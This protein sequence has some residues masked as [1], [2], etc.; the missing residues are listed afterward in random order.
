[1]R[2][3]RLGYLL[4]FLL[5][6]ACNLGRL[7][8]SI[9]L[10]TLESTQSTAPTSKSSLPSSPTL[11]VPS[12]HTLTPQAT[13]TPGEINQCQNL[14]H[15]IIQGA[16]WEYQM[17]SF[18]SRTT[19]TRTIISVHN[20]GFEM[21]DALNTGVAH[22]YAWVCQNGNLTGF[23]LSSLLASPDV[24]GENIIES[25]EGISLPANPQVGQSWAQN[26]T[27]RTQVTAG[28]TT[29]E[30]HNEASIL[31]KANNMERIT[32][33]AGDFS[34][35][36][37]EC[38][39]E[40]KIRILDTALTVATSRSDWYAPTVGL[41]KSSGSSEMGTFELLLLTYHLP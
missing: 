9:V 34:A 28:G 19:L 3:L 39:A 8:S 6:L 5:S 24:Q 15:P 31:C 41:V 22:Q 30:G 38:S 36:R 26:I 13:S 4:F 7:P 10:P 25:N 17:N 35:L 11:A 21:Q 23:T 12:P 33:P 16:S 18:G 1:M 37:V 14:Y 29:I 27:Y 20:N 32:V 2:F 40:V